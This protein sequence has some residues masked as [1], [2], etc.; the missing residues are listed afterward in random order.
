[1]N[2]LELVR[3]RIKAKRQS[4][5]YSY[6]DLAKLTKLSKST[7]QR[8]E[9]GNIG[10]LPI[11]KLGILAKAL[12]CDPA[13][14]MGWELTDEHS[15]APGFMP[16]PE[17]RKVPLVG[18]IA[19]GTPVLA[20]ENIEDYLDVPRG[21]RVDFCL[22]CEGDSMIDAGIEDG[23]IVYIRRQPD[24]ENGQIAAV[25][26]GDEATLKRVYKFPDRLV[27]QAENRSYPPLTFVG[28]EMNEIIIEG[29]AVGWVHWV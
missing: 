16:L 14:L 13:Y 7:L 22:M 23:D 21:T 18:R 26:V 17:M 19:C 8:Y 12:H 29:K 4:L 11:D 24:V 6:Q 10:N 20:Q 15:P 25:R 5:G 1:M 9:T 2:D 3:K 27:L 28:E